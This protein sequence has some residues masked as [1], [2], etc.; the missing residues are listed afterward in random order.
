MGLGV[1][2]AV[3]AVVVGGVTGLPQVV[4]PVGRDRLGRLLRVV[5]G[6]GEVAVQ[7][8]GGDLLTEQT[9]RRCSTR[10]STACAAGG[11][12]RR[13]FTHTSMAPSSASTR[14]AARSTCSASAT[15]VG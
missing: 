11:P 13:P 1:E 6:A 9:S 3:A 14:S 4:R 15:S 5:A 10:P 8:G 12:P 2:D 7:Q